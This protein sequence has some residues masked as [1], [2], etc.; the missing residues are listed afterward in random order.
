MAGQGAGREAAESKPL[1]LTEDGTQRSKPE[2][3]EGLVEKGEKKEHLPL[4]PRAACTAPAR[5]S[6]TQGTVETAKGWVVEELAAASPVASAKLLSQLQCRPTL[7]LSLLQEILARLKWRLCGM[8]C[9]N[10]LHRTVV[11]CPKN[12]CKALS[13]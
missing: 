1:F 12:T 8:C 9:C 4:R 11:C 7:L 3:A 6:G 10:S 2:Q 13:C 5:V